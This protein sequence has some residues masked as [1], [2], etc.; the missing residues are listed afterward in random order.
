MARWRP[1]WL[2]AFGIH[3]LL[4][5][6]KQLGRRQLKELKSLRGRGA[7][8]G[9]NTPAQQF[10][11][12]GH[13]SAR[14][15][16]PDI[17]PMFLKAF[18]FFFF[19]RF[20]YSKKKRDLKKVTSGWKNPKTSSGTVLQRW[21]SRSRGRSRRGQRQRSARTRP[22]EPTPK[23]LQTPRADHAGQTNAE[24][25]R[26]AT[27]PVLLAGTCWMPPGSFLGGLWFIYGLA[28]GRDV[29]GVGVGVEGVLPWPN[30]AMRYTSSAPRKPSIRHTT[31][32]SF[33]SQPS[34]HTVPQRRS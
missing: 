19:P 22:R 17:S 24:G 12:K 2:L 28:P 30:R 27:A 23:D 20:C 10:G 3:H 26:A 5:S 29:D 16:L 8:L 33:L 25:S 7:G 31:S 32:P 13:P 6:P 15:S 4:S 34:S 18:P 11:A 1:R 14:Q 9:R 21:V